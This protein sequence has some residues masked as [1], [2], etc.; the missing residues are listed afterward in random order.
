MKPA[1]HIFYSAA[2]A[3]KAL[4][5]VIGED[6]FKNVEISKET[7]DDDLDPWASDTTKW[8]SYAYAN[9]PELI[10]MKEEKFAQFY[11]WWLNDAIPEAWSLASKR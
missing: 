4:S 6:P 5:E 11:I 3:Y 8:A 7:S 9:R 2:A 10:M 1:K